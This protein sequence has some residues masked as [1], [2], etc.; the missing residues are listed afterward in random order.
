[1]GGYTCYFPIGIYFIDRYGCDG[2]GWFFGGDDEGVIRT[3]GL[4]FL[5]GGSG[6][7]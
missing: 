5:D 1:M 2:L 4:P 6:S 7:I 3:L